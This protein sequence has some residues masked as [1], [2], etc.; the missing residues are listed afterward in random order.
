MEG[1]GFESLIERICCPFRT[2]VA[3]PR[4]GYL[5][6]TAMAIVLYVAIAT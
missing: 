1:D 5:S 2:K 3:A 6:T 4:P